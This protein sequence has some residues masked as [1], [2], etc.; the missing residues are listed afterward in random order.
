[1]L[2]YHPDIR[3]VELRTFNKTLSRDIRCPDRDSNRAPSEHMSEPT[4]TVVPVESKSGALR[5]TLR[6][7]T[8][9]RGKYRSVGMTF[10]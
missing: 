5:L 1:M 6:Y 4:M 8:A 9:L 3:Q 10:V 2:Q 7:S